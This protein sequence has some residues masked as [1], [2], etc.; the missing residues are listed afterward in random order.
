MIKRLV[1]KHSDLMVVDEE[2]RFAEQ[3][4]TIQDKIVNEAATRPV[5]YERRPDI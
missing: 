1:M 5:E 3:F 2:Q 4:K